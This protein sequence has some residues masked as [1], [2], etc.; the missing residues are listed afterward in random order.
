MKITLV[1]KAD[2]SDKQPLLVQYNEGADVEKGIVGKKIT[3]SIGIGETIELPDQEA[4]EVMGKYKGLF[5]MAGE[6]DAVGQATSG[7][8]Y[9][10]KAASA[11]G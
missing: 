6:G 2:P 11:Q 7:K 5:K 10:H 4:Y 3:K 1:K 8:G 9:A